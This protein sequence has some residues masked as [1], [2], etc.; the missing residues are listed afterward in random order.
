MRARSDREWIYLPYSECPVTIGLSAIR[1]QYLREL[2]RH[3]I[4]SE[5]EHSGSPTFGVELPPRE[6]VHSLASERHA[7]ASLRNC[8]ATEFL[9][10]TR[11]VDGVCV[12]VQKGKIKSPDGR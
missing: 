5:P 11:P 10:R 4:V 2:R 7:H 1:R 12:C 3:V 9:D 6:T 8:K